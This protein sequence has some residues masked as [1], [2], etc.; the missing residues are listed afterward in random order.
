MGNQDTNSPFTGVS[1]EERRIMGRLL[2][3]R[4]EPQKAASKPTGGRAEAQR[5]RRERER[6]AGHDGREQKVHD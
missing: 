6:K 2:R 4:P 1:D 3:M 5:R